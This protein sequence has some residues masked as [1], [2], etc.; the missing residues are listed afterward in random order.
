MT[1]DIN[2][3]AGFATAAMVLFTYLKKQRDDDKA[4]LEAAKE[5]E[6]AKK[7]IAEKIDANTIVTT[8]T[9]D[10][11]NGQR[12]AMLAKL[13]FLEDLL[14]R[15]NPGDSVAKALS[16]QAAKD[17]TD[18]TITQLHGEKARD[19]RAIVKEE[20][21]AAKAAPPTIAPLPETK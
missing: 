15:L 3:I 17:V 19:E 9:H 12:T 13:K 14:V 21:E 8:N 16:D 18:D 7:E 5:R 11:V 2:T 10:L 20:K 1:V 6:A 4:K